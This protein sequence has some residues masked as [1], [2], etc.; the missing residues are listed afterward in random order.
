MAEVI[1]TFAAISSV[2]QVIQFS[3]RLIEATYHLFYEK[4]RD[5]SVDEYLDTLVRQYEKLYNDSSTLPKQNS[6]AEELAVLAQQQL[7]QFEAAELLVRLDAM[8]STSGVSLG[9]RVWQEAK[10]AIAGKNGRKEIEECR[11]RLREL[12]GLLGTSILQLLLSKHNEQVQLVLALHQDLRESRDEAKVLRLDEG[13]KNMREHILESLT[14]QEMSTRYHS[15]QK[16]YPE[17]YVWAVK[18]DAFG[19]STWLRSGNGIFWISGKAGSGKSTLMKFLSQSDDTEMLLTQWAGPNERLI[20]ASFY[21]WYL[22]SA[23]QKSIEGLLRGILYQIIEQ[24]PDLGHVAFPSLFEAFIPPSS[25]SSW[26]YEEL[27]RALGIIAAH[28]DAGGMATKICLFIDGLDEYSADQSRLLGLLRTFALSFNIKLCVSSRPWNAFRNAFESKTPNIQLEDLTYSDIR[29]Y[30]EGSIRACQSELDASFG[31]TDD[32]LYDP[33]NGTW[34]KADDGESEALEHQRTDEVSR[35]A[36]E[37]VRKAEGV[38][39]WVYLVV[40]SI[41]SGLAEGDSL[42]MLRHRIREFPSDLGDFFETIL[43]RVDAVYRHQTTQALKLACL[44]SDRHGVRTKD[45][46]MT[47]KEDDDLDFEEDDVTLLSSWIDFWLISQ[48]PYGL[49]KSRSLYGVKCQLLKPDNLAQMYAQTRKF[50]SAS[51]RDLLFLPKLEGIALQNG[52]WTKVQFL[53]RTVYEFLCEQRQIRDKIDHQVPQLF[54]S[55]RILHLLNLTRLKFETTGNV[56]ARRCEIVKRSAIQSLAT[57]H[58]DLNAEFAA[59]FESVLTF[60]GS[61]CGCDDWKAQESGPFGTDLLSVDMLPAITV[62][63][64]FGSHGWATHFLSAFLNKFRAEISTGRDPSV[65]S[66]PALRNIFHAAMGYDSHRNFDVNHIH[67]PLVGAL[68]GFWDRCVRP[69]KIPNAWSSCNTSFWELFLFKWATSP[70]NVDLSHAWNIAKLF[71]AK[72]WDVHD[73]FCT[74][75]EPTDHQGHT[76]HEAKQFLEYHVP[77]EWMLKIGNPCLVENCGHEPHAT[78]CQRFSSGLDDHG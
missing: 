61:Q 4:G 68:L 8:T 22:G 46:E 37:I 73:T 9:K 40:R 24:H 20:T 14:Y 63:V 49:H 51:C 19:I 43:S 71:L 17:T 2:L 28:R 56:K 11:E 42:R 27:L 44:Y 41:L 36:D 39:L 3:S 35:I 60:H 34:N 15:I 69:G 65:S 10:K 47:L 45:D 62:L 53:H 25:L 52:L 12:N 26:S 58:A 32:V 29:L 50:L 30:V 48:T 72:D 74:Y 38:F 67:M 18:N 31:V 6:T 77:P 5:R 70:E 54:Q 33:A 21:F 78:A 1:A 76:V 57:D 75:S 16:N 66:I 23:A 55:D 64:A 59:Q 13:L 7:C